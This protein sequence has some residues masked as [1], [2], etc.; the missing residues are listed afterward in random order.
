MATP[1]A[2]ATTAR[3]NVRRRRRRSEVERANGLQWDRTPSLAH[4]AET[5]LVDLN[6]GRPR[7]Y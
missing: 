2:T 1:A 7:I 6:D 3:I 5:D 4:E